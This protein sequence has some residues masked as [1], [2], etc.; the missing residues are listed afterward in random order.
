M[1]QGSGMAVAEHYFMCW[2][3]VPAQRRELAPL[4]SP[5]VWRTPL[6]NPWAPEC[7]PDLPDRD[8]VPNAPGGTST[9]KPFVE[10]RGAASG[11]PP[12]R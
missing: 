7:P 3:V 4:G 11:A 1:L 8:W 5:H 12:L 9:C 10:G 6:V 2:E